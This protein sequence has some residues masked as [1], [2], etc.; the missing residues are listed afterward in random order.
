M[1]NIRPT[2][3]KRAAIEI[4]KKYPDQ[5]SDDFQHNKV[6][7]NKVAE[8]P[9]ISLRNKVA[10]YITRYRKVLANRI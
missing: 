4:L 8:I 2:F 10:G 9:S 7:L 1:G 3:I 5:F 6:V